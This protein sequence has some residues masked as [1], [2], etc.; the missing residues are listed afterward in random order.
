MAKAYL[1]DERILILERKAR[2]DIKQSH[3]GCGDQT[4]AGDVTGLDFQED[5]QLG[6]SFSKEPTASA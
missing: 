2:Q 5:A 1:S 6:V 3:T 4:D